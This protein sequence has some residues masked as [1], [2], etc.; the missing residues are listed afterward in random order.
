MVLPWV[1]KIRNIE[2]HSQLIRYAHMPKV[3]VSLHDDDD[4]N[5]VC[6]MRFDA[7]GMSEDA[8]KRAVRT[9]MDEVEG[10]RTVGDSIECVTLSDPEVLVHSPG[11]E[12][13]AT[14]RMQRMVVER[15]VNTDPFRVDRAETFGDVSG[16]G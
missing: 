11:M 8:I 13:V 14:A 12:V 7:S 1:K 10:I 5:P 2:E 4:G 3:T 16:R 9:T 15:S 6:R